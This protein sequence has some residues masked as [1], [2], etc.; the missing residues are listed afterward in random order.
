MPTGLT[1][2]L[3]CIRSI[4]EQDSVSSIKPDSS[5][6]RQI[7]DHT[8]SPCYTKTPLFFSP[9]T[10]CCRVVCV[11]LVND[12]VY[13]G[14]VAVS[15][16]SPRSP[17]LLIIYNNQALTSD[18]SMTRTQSASEERTEDKEEVKTKEG[19]EKLVG[20]EHK[21][22]ASGNT[23]GLTTTSH[24]HIAE[25]AARETCDVDSTTTTDEDTTKESKRIIFVPPLRIP[26]NSDCL[27]GNMERD[28]SLWNDTHM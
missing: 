21:R 26:A 8:V 15:S 5:V 18:V 17:R 2:T 10:S 14:C 12:R 23:L 20:I 28:W 1:Y 27:A 6:L 22:R 24:D 13:R 3:Y 7:T 11:A 16:V 9:Q 19:C 25:S 4:F